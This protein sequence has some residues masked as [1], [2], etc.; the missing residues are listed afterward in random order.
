MHTLWTRIAHPVSLVLLLAAAGAVTAQQPYPSRPVR[1]IVPFPPGGSTDPIARMVAAKLTEKWGQ[2]VIVDNRPGGNTIIGTDFLAK[3]TP[4]GYT[5]GWVGPSFFST[6]S[7]IPKLPYDS[8]RDFVGVTTIARQRSLLVLHPSVPARNL[9]EV[10]ALAKSRPGQLNFGS[11]GIGTNVHLAGELFK[12]LTGTNIVHI[13]YK[14]SG[15]LSTDLIAGRV[16]MSFQ[17]PITVIPHINGGKLRPIAVSGETRLP[18][19][20]EVP[21][22][23]EA[24]LPGYGLTSVNGIIAP[25]RT[26]RQAIGSIAGEVAAMLARPDTLDF[27]ARQGAEPLVSTPE[28]TGALIKEELGRYARIIKEAGIK[29]QP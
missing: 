20:P 6:P 4:D 22:F 19:L 14:G 16:E 3:A 7:L 17:V 29:Y 5:I 27:L 24:G 8:L 10:I 18:P 25:A 15:P 9:Q 13:P 11:S 28:Q 26:P 12:I 21:T 23:S 1:Y 2:S